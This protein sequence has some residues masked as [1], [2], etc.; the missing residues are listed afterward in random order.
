MSLNEL[1]SYLFYIQWLGCKFFSASLIGKEFEQLIKT[2][3]LIVFFNELKLC[4]VTNLLNNSCKITIAIGFNDHRIS[5]SKPE[6][7]RKE[8]LW[9]RKAGR[10]FSEEDD[11][12]IYVIG[13]W[14]EK[15]WPNTCWPDKW[16]N[17]EDETQTLVEVE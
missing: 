13:S 12:K 14:K 3:D 4:S 10:R 5:F 17:N 2:F 1:N 15:F 16:E 8:I 11:S 6:S 9:R 7:L